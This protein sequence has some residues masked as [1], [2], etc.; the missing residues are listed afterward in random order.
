MF[1]KYIWPGFKLLLSLSLLAALLAFIVA[2]PQ[3]LADPSVW[4]LSSILLVMAALPWVDFERPNRA[5]G[6][7]GLVFGLGVGFAA[8]Q[9]AFGVTEWPRA[10]RGRSSLICELQNLLWLAGGPTL[11]ALPLL[12]VAVALFWGGARLVRRTNYR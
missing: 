8:W 7:S 4:G 9:T 11:A 1:V 3:A 2:A 6:L 12:V 10:C 5:L